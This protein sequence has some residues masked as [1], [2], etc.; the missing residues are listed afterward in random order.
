MRVYDIE[1]EEYH[2][3]NDYHFIHHWVDRIFI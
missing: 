3:E 1:T 2:D